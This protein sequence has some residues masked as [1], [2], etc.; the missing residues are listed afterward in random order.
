[1]DEWTV[2]WI[3]KWL[4]L[5]TQRFVISGTGSDWRHV[6]GGVLQGSIL[7]PVLFK[8]AISDLDKGTGASSVSSP[9]DTKLRGVANTPDRCVALQRDIDRLERW[10]ENC[11]KFNKGKCRV[12]HLMYQY[13][14]STDLLESSS[15]E[16]DL[17]IPM[18]NK[19]PKSQQCPVVKEALGILGCFRESTA[20]R[21]RLVMLLLYSALVR[22]IWSAV[23]YSAL[24]STGEMRSSWSR[25][26]GQ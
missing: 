5:R 15:V 20:S 19:L 8:F 11:L 17:S 18:D 2:R 13:R 21:L 22:N 3:E 14:L 4:N 1:M 25:S 7:G 26:S 23:S 12:L 10:A 6:P 24:L 16:E 9:C